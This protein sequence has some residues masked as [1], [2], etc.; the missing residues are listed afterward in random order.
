MSDGRLFGAEA[1]LRRFR[2]DGPVS[3]LEIV[4]A[5]KNIVIEW[6]LDKWDVD[7]EYIEILEMESINNF[8]ATRDILSRCEALGVK[9]SL[10]DFGTGY[11]SLTYFHALPISKLKIDQSFI[12]NINSDRESLLLV[13]SILAIADTNDKPVVAEGI[14]TDAIARTLAELNCEFGQ[15]YGIAEP[16]P[17]EQY[18]NWTQER[19]VKSTT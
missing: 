4:A 19:L 10:D 8:D 2:P 5:I 18:I 15:G 12:K 7:D 3:P 14:E 1:L 13:K 11:S 16:M 6:Q 9:F 17:I